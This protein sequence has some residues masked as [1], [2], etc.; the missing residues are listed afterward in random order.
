MTARRAG[1]RPVHVVFAGLPGVGKT[2]IAGELARRLAA[3]YLRID[4]LEHALSRSGAVVLSELGP[5][6]YHAAAAVAVDN[7][8]N[9]VSVVTDS[10]NP[11]P[12][13]RRLWQDASVRGRA[14][15]VGIEVVCSDAGEHRRRVEGR[16]SDIVDCV[17]PDWEAVQSRQYEAW[18]EA[19]MRLDTAFLDASRAVDEALALI[20][21]LRKAE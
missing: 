21:A 14:V 20:T 4:T 5:G 11:W 15:G 13:T 17:L 9:D 6:G 16:V 19:D 10:V 12:I 2:T 3:A 8:L 18:D 1:E 7:L